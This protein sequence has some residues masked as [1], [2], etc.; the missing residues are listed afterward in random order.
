MSI[1]AK[2][3]Y[4]FKFFIFKINRSGSGTI[5]TEIVGTPPPLVL[6]KST[7]HTRPQT[8]KMKEKRSKVWHFLSDDPA[9]SDPET[10]Y[11][12]VCILCKKKINTSNNT[13]NADAHMKRWHKKEYLTWKS[14]EIENETDAESVDDVE[15]IGDVDNSN[16]QPVV[17][18]KNN[19]L[20]VRNF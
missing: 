1:R 18:E 10:S 15:P 11:I 9:E 20:L 8:K 13:S 19:V 17:A 16:I 5:R 2:S 3:K 12:K 6:S 14:L 4:L 7:K